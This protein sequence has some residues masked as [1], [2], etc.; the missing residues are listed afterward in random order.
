MPPKQQETED[1]DEHQITL[2]KNRDKD[3][4]LPSIKK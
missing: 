3:Q 4:I 2:N 1:S